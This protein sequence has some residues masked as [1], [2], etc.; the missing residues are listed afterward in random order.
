MAGPAGGNSLV[1]GVGDLVRFLDGLLAGR[2]FRHP[3]TLQAMLAFQPADGEPGQVGYGL[4]LLRRVLPGGVET[5]DHLGGAVGF[6]AHVARLRRQQVTLATAMNSLADPS[7][8]VL[9]VL[10][11]FANPG[12]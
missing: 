10:Q 2:L 8:L 6:R 12:R 1:T 7:Q 3:A 5:I 4:G 11:A 9:P